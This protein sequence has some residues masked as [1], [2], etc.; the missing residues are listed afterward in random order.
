MEKVG[1]QGLMTRLRY[2]WRGGRLREAVGSGSLVRLVEV[3][4]ADA[5]WVISG[6]GLKVRDEHQATCS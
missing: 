2:D 6:E 3:V 4:P 5:G 1:L